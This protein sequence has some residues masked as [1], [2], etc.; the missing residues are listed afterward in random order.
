MSKAPKPEPKATPKK[1]P[2]VMAA[3]QKATAQTAQQAAQQAKPTSTSIAE[4]VK[5]GAIQPKA[6]GLKIVKELN[7]W[8]LD[9][10]NAER[11]MLEVETRD[12]TRRVDCVAAIC[13]SADRDNNIKEMLRLV[14]GKKGDK[15]KVKDRI[16]VALGIREIK[17]SEDGVQTYPY[18]PEVH[19]MMFLKE[20]EKEGSQT[21]KGK[22]TFRTNY[23]NFIFDC[24]RMAHV[25]EEQKVMITIETRQIEDKTGR[26]REEKNI[27]VSDKP[28]SKGVLERFGM[29]SVVLDG[30]KSVFVGMEGDKERHEELKAI[31]GFAEMARWSR[32]VGEQAATPGSGKASK[33]GGSAGNTADVS[34][35]GKDQLHTLIDN[36]KSMA[37]TVSKVEISN[38]DLYDALVRLRDVINEAVA[39]RLDPELQKKVSGKAA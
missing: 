12:R 31:P 23:T 5:K 28:G 13:Y 30:K 25:V 15:S 16:E 17:V 1:E 26:M 22:E 33:K 7:T 36:A 20:G 8:E 39:K 4:Y 38:P 37:L 14:N 11:A 18:I 34:V 19:E 29:D 27:R 9:K 2:E 3:D 35:Q 10:Y 24:I 32:D 6:V 21:A